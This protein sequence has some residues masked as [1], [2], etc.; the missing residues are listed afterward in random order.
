ADALFFLPVE[1]GFSQMTKPVACQPAGKYYALDFHVVW[2]RD[3]KWLKE[4]DFFGRYDW[5]NRVGEPGGEPAGEDIWIKILGDHVEPLPVRGERGDALGLYV[6]NFDKHFPNGIDLCTHVD[7][8]TFQWVLW[9]MGH[10]EFA[11]SL[12]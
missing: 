8:G 6:G 9:K 10:G 7:I 5:Q 1:W 2:W 3:L 12:L 4:F 11:T